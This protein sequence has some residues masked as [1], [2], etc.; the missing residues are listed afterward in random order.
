MNQDQCVEQS[1]KGRG[2]VLPAEGTADKDRKEGASRGAA[3][4]A[5]DKSWSGEL[6][7]V[8]P[9]AQKSSRK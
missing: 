7:R 5:E 9:E 2:R 8:C 1:Q 4:M 3:T 6:R